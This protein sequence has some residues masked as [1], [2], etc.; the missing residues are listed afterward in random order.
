MKKKWKP[1]FECYGKGNLY[2]TPTQLMSTTP[3]SVRAQHNKPRLRYRSVFGVYGRLLL[4]LL[5]QTPQPN[6]MKERMKYFYKYTH[7]HACIER[8]HA[9]LYPYV[10]RT[11]PYTHH[12]YT[13]TV[14][15]TRSHW[16]IDIV[17]RSGCCCH[18]LDTFRRFNIIFCCFFWF[19]NVV[20]ISSVCM[21]V[22]KS[23]SNDTGSG[24]WYVILTTTHRHTHT[25]TRTAHSYAMQSPSSKYIKIFEWMQ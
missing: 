17:D 19:R 2:A 20:C 8:R 13:Q 25:N 16:H 4:L 18:C 5:Y 12:S 3:Q 9:Q 10:Q 14:R 23:H 24:E 11:I 7:I 6:E 21:R 15:G 22:S 1:E